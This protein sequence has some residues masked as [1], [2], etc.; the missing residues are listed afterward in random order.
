[1]DRWLLDILGEDYQKALLD[2]AMDDLC[3]VRIRT[4]QPLILSVRGQEI[5]VWPR[6]SQQILEDLLQYACRFSMYAYTDMVSRGFIPLPGG[7]R[8]GIC[9]SGVLQ[10]GQVKN[11]TEVTSVSIRIAKDVPGCANSIMSF[12][13][14]ST[15][16]AG[17][18]GSGKT[19][20]LRDVIRQ[21][22]DHRK[23]R[24]SLVDERGEIASCVRGIPQLEIGMRTDVMSYVP[25]AEAM[26]MLLRSMNPQWIAVD[27]I[28]DPDDVEA[29]VRASYCGVQMLATAHMTDET[30]LKKRP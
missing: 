22:S 6:V 28:T 14:Q 18:P 24:A 15:L 11:M 17:P 10:N 4:G 12:L 19:T 8:I 3:E 16:F 27:E 13:H 26:I 2:I 5:I 20:I 9:G 23:Q 21:L 7:H 30:D 29:M 25:K 1:M